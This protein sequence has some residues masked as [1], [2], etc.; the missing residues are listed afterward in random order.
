MTP[1]RAGRRRIGPPP[2]ILGRGVNVYLVELEE[3]L[4]KLWHSEAGGIP[5]GFKN[6]APPSIAIDGASSAGTE[7]N[8]WAAADHTHGIATGDPAAIRLGQPNAEGTAD[9]V[10]RADHVGDTIVLS[11]QIRALVSLR[12][13]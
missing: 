9:A 13:G 11:G 2:R 3:W 6:I 4:L 12:I 1:A 5:P 8:G 7:N 10:A